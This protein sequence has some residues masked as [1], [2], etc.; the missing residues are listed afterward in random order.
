[1]C[2]QLLFV[3]AP[4]FFRSLDHLLILSFDLLTVLVNVGQHVRHLLL[5]QIEFVADQLGRI[6]LLDKVH[7][8]VERDARAGHTQAALGAE[9]VGCAFG[10]PFVVV[11]IIAPAF[12][13]LLFAW[14]Q[15]SR[16]IVRFALQLLH[17]FHK[18]RSVLALGVGERPSLAFVV[19]VLRVEPLRLFVMPD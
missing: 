4:P 10:C 7:N 14:R 12:L 5:G 17:L 13:R 6:V 3:V 1:M 19:P 8:R 15:T 9:T 11:S 16:R 2:A 18:G